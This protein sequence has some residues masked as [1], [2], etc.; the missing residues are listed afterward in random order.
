MS[1]YR[2]ATAIQVVAH[3][4]QGIFSPA[5][6]AQAGQEFCDTCKAPVPSKVH[7]FEPVLTDEAGRHLIEQFFATERQKI[8]IAQRMAVLGHQP[9]PEALR[10]QRHEL[11]L[12]GILRRLLTNEE[13]IRLE[14]EAS[15]AIVKGLALMLERVEQNARASRLAPATLA[16]AEQLMRMM[17]E[18]GSGGLS[19]G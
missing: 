1:Q 15:E 18:N 7:E 12:D 10:G 17:R 6:G 16:D 2:S 3:V 8:E 5:H 9:D 14:I 19:Q 4:P 11:L 13:R